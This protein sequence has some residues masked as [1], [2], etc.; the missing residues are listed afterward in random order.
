MKKKTIEK[1]CL[2]MSQ[3]IIRNDKRLFSRNCSAL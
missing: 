2:L 3:N 1:S